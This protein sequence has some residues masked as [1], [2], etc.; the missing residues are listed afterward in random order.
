MPPAAAPTITV[1]VPDPPVA[2]DAARP[3]VSKP[4]VSKSAE[5]RRAG[6]EARQAE[7]AERSRLAAERSEK[8]RLATERARTPVREPVNPSPAK[9]ASRVQSEVHSSISQLEG[10]QY[11]ALRK[12]LVEQQAQ[13]QAILLRMEERMVA[14][15]A[16]HAEEK[17]QL[18]QVVEEQSLQLCTLTENL[19]QMLVALTET[20]GQTGGA[21]Q[22]AQAGF[23]LQAEMPATL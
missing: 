17:Q 5:A 8:S 18:M 20:L 11:E 13:H 1:T 15:A 3:H 9:S 12:L 16:A 21:L 14:E 23:A 22:A 4:A 10:G 7:R 19:A 2:S 6:A